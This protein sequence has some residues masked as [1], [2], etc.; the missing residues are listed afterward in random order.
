MSINAGSDAAKGEL[1]I[2]LVGGQSVAATVEVSLDT[3]ENPKNK[4]SI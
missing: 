4:T 2:L 3:S 1:N